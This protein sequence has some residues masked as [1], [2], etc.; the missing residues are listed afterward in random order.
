[1]TTTSRIQTRGE[2][3]DSANIPRAFNFDVTHTA[4]RTDLYSWPFLRPCPPLTDYQKHSVI[5]TH[6]R[7]K[8]SWVVISLH[9]S[10]IARSRME[11]D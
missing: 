10:Q 8:N 9:S 7:A 1:V 11:G 3:R 4:P 2:E 5:G 6:V